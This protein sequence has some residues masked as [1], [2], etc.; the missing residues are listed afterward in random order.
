M[1]PHFLHYPH[2]KTSFRWQPSGYLHDACHRL[3]SS[4]NHLSS[5]LLPFINVCVNPWMMCGCMYV[6]LNVWVEHNDICI[7]PSSNDTLLRVHVENLCSSCAC[8]AYKVRWSNQPCGQI[9]WMH[10]RAK[11]WNLSSATCF[12][13]PLVLV[14]S[15]ICYILS[16]SLMKCSFK[17]LWHFSYIQME[18]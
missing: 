8:D 13:N 18:N 11:Q 12:G 16:Q 14:N 9:M 5:Y 3:T 2:Y 15:T 6:M 1:K 4:G 10:Q 17:C 7:W